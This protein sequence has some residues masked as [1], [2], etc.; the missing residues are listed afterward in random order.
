MSLNGQIS[1]A[2]VQFYFNAEIGGIEQT[3]ALVLFYGPHDKNLFEESFYTLWSMAEPDRN[4]LKVIGAKSI[5]AVVSVQPHNHHVE[6]NDTR[7]FVWEQMGLEMG[8]LA[9]TLPA[10]EA[11]NED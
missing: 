10:I 3:L 4:N 2:E 5:A 9:D 1:F 11:E 6:E 7:Y 8:L